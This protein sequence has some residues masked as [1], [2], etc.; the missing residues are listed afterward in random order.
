MNEDPCTDQCQRCQVC[1][2]CLIHGNSDHSMCWKR[3]R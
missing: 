2:G 1:Q 3:K